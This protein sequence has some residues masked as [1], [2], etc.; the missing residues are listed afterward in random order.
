L[1]L[2]RPPDGFRL[3]LSVGTTFSLDLISALMLP[4]AFTFGWEREG[5][6]EPNPLA[7]LESL[8]E[9]GHRFTVFC[10]SG[11]IR[12]AQRKHA[13]LLTFLE[14]CVYDVQSREPGGVFHP[15]VWA[16]RYTGEGGS[17]RYRVLCLSRN[18]TFD[19]SWD[20]AVVLDGELTERERAFAVNHPLGDFIAALPGLCC[21]RGARF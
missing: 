7:I 11:Q 2:V 6:D 1:E 19:R 3:D 9:H 10:Q 8:R 16:L 21:P 17:V 4:L 15:K 18:L 5:E 13:Q 12:L 20:T 14:P